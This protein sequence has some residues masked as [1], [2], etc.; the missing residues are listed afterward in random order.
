MYLSKLTLNLY[1]K[2]ARREIASPYE[3]HRTLAKAFAQNG[4][5]AGNRM[6]FRIEAPQNN[7]ISSGI[8]VIVQS[9]NIDPVWDN[10]TVKGD[11]FLNEPQTK[12]VNLGNLPVG[13]Y[14]F[15]LIANPTIKKNGKRFGLY[16]EEEQL[17][18]LKRKG[19][20]HGFEPVFVNCSGF[21]IGSKSK[22]NKMEQDKAKKSDIYHFGV[23]FEGVIKINDASK[24]IEAL[25]SGIGSAKAFGFGLLTVARI[26]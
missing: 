21:T 8:D 10:L 23:T 13:I 4:D 16:K 6:L 1:N 3:M 19:R 22:T 2:Q 26:E 24:A 20:Q 12:K 15:R 25:L 5:F 7:S 18:W 9:R 14:K 17:D 11:Y